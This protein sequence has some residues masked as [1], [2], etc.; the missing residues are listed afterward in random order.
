MMVDLKQSRATAVLASAL[1]FGA[2]PPLTKMFLAASHPLFIAGLLYAGSG[3]G[4]SL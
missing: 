1:L 4:V 3:L 2:T